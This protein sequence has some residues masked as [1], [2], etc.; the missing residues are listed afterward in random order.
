M[1]P[2]DFVLAL[3]LQL[4]FEIPFYIL[5]LLTDITHEM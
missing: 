4:K 2:T 5:R 3:V 1:G